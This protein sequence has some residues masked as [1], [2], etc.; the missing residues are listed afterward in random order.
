M[1]ADIRLTGPFWV[2]KGV[3]KLQAVITCTNGEKVTHSW[4]RH[5]TRES[6]LTY[7]ES[8]NDLGKLDV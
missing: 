5:D 8:F 3:W 6:A 4:S 7:L 2:A 1:K